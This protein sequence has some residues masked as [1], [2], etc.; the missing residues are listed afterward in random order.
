[1]AKKLAH[2]SED[3]SREQTV[4]EHLT[5]TAELAKQFAAAFGAEEDGYL[6]GLL[7]D[8]GKYSDAFQHRLDGGVRVDHSTAGAKEACAHGVGYLALAIAGHHGGI[9]NFGSRAD[10]KNDATLSGRLKRDLEPYDDWKT[11][12]TL[13]PVKPF[14]MREFNTGFRLSFYIRM[15][16]SCLVD[17]DFIDTETFMDG[18]LAPRGNYDALPALLDRLETYIAPWYPPKAELNRKRCAILD[19]CKASGSTAAPGVYTL[20]VPTGGGKT[21]AAMAFALTAAVQNCMSRVIYAAPYTSIIDQNADTFEK[22]FGT[23]NVIEHHSSAEYLFSE[24]PNPAEYRK[25]LAAENWDAPVIATTTVQLF[26]SLF[27][28]KPARCRKLHNLANSVLILDEVQTLPM[29]YLK[30]FTAA[31]AEL[32]RKYGVIVVLCPAHRKARIKEIRERLKI[33]LPCRV[34]STSLIEAGVD[35]DFPRV[36]RE[37]AGLDSVLQAAGRCNREGKR[38]LDESLVTV[39]TVQNTT[40]PPYMRQPAAAMKNISKR[41]E[42]IT[43]LAAIRAYFEFYRDLYGKEDL[44]REKILKAFESGTLPFASV[45]EKVRVIESCTTPVYIPI[46]QGEALVERLYRGE[47]SRALFR[48]LGQYSVNVYPQQ[49][50]ALREAGA[51]QSI[52]GGALYVLADPRRYDSAL[53]LTLDQTETALFI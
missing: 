25:M 30:P 53:G 43:S 51:V 23:E 27:A 34:V 26:E 15:L 22:I 36:Y 20:T 45:A 50:A 33:G 38:P 40:P 19:A 35:V 3:H 6:L 14:N 24:S 11:E 21:T 1:M 52:D 48:K 47:R 5:G 12:V 8:I 17:A 28:S 7:H 49:L 10:T 4:Y 16:F 41:M 42:D 18:A 29:P 31:L 46:D 37:E 44:D 13:P 2:I 32:A 39:F 9:P